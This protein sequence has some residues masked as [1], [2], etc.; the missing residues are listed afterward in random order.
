MCGG[1]HVGSPCIPLGRGV[2]HWVVL[3]P[4]FKPELGIP[5]KE[6]VGSHC[7][8]RG[9]SIIFGF[10]SSDVSLFPY[11]LIPL[12]TLLLVMLFFPVF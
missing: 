3:W 5:G 9:P 6:V 7:Y 11:P 4:F 1:V 12:A 2:Q 8:S 10:C